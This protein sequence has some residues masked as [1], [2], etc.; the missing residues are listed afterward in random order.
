MT[1]AI[2]TATATQ[3]GRLEIRGVRRDRPDADKIAKVLIELAREQMADK[4]SRRDDRTAIGVESSSLPPRR[5]TK[6]K[7]FAGQSGFL[8]AFRAM[9]DAG[10]GRNLSTLVVLDV[11]R[12]LDTGDVWVPWLLD[13]NG[14]VIEPAAM[15]FAELQAADK[16]P[17]TIRSYG[18]DLLRWWRFLAAIDVPWNR[19]TPVEGRDFARWMQLADKPIRQHWRHAAGGVDASGGRRRLYPRARQLAGQA[20]TA[21]MTWSNFASGSTLRSRTRLRSG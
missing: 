11:E 1:I 4:P 15:F 12:L 6:S 3:R 19:A 2:N 13:A 20:R 21:G 17:S 18:N 7:V 16:R 9:G 8:I 5:F 10:A 14:V